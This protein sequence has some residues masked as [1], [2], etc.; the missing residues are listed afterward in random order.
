MHSEKNKKQKTKNKSVNQLKRQMLSL[1]ITSTSPIPKDVMGKTHREHI[2][3]WTTFHLV[4]NMD[5]E[6]KDSKREIFY[7]LI[8]F[9][10]FQ[11]Y[12]RIQF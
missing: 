7:C 8:F 6:F 5:Y 3:I 1:T 4:S 10:R 11:R 9:F 12:F 2:S